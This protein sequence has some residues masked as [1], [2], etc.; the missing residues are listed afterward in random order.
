MKAYE[1]MNHLESY[2]PLHLQ[3]DFDNAFKNVDIIIS[4]TSPVTAGLLGTRDQTDSALSFLAD[5]YA[6]NINLVGLP[7]MSV[8]AGLDKNNMPIGI[9]FIA[10]Q[11]NETDM[12]RMAYAHELASK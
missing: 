2:F 9:Q 6:S 10:K 7:A 4:P 1:I 11:F 5:S 3:M 12:F 8:P